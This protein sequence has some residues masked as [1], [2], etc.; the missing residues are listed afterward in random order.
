MYVVRSFEKRK[1]RLRE[2]NLS[3]KI[4]SSL[5]LLVYVIYIYIYIYISIVDFLFS[6]LTVGCYSKYIEGFIV[7]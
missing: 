2:K 6:S 4:K 5:E 1:M 7:W 3:P